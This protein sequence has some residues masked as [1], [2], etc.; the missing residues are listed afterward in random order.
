MRQQIAASLDPSVCCCLT[1]H[2]HRR[3]SNVKKQIL[4]M[5]GL[6][7]MGGGIAVNLAKAGYEI[8][9]F[10]LRPEAMARVPEAGGKAAASAEAIARDCD[11][12]MTSLEGL[13]YIKVAEEILLPMAR[14]GQTFIDFS[15]VPCPETRRLGQAFL[16]KGCKYLEAPSSGGAP[17][18]DAGKLR[19]FVG[20]E[21]STADEYWPLFEVAGNPEKVVYCGGL[22]MGQAAKVVQQLTHR[23]PELARMETMAFGLRAGLELDVVMRALDVK[24]GD[25]DPYAYLFECIKN[26]NTDHLGVLF[27]EWKYYLEEAD[28]TGFRMPMLE[29]MY[30]FCKEGER[31][32]VDPLQRPMPSVWNEL[33]RGK[34]RMS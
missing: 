19:I 22:G 32:T 15:T 8:Y 34:G 1:Q 31:V 23:L 18:A 16:D 5:I 12:V 6:G 20:G 9:G 11:V 3:K 10:D 26:N 24:P 14:S 25:K 33:M 4:G 29:A 28:A 27:S 7:Q 17:L 13:I 21:K 2:N 30:E